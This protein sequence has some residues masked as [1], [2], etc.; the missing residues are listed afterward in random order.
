M[1]WV[2]KQVSKTGNQE[3]RW[4]KKQSRKAVVSVE[5]S[6]RKGEKPS[7]AEGSRERG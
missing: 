5:M 1:Y 3:K 7:P 2:C 6:G 4:R